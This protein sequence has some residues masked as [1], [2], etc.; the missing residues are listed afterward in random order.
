MIK[1]TISIVVSL[2]SFYISFAQNV[3]IGIPIPNEKLDV[4]GNVKATGMILTTGGAEYDFLMKNNV[5]G[6]VG[7]K[8]G[9][10]AQAIHYMIATNAFFPSESG[11]AN[12]TNTLTGEIK[13]FAGNILPSGWL[14]CEGQL[15]NI[16]SYVPLF[17]VI[18]FTY[19][20]D[21]Q[22]VFAL[23]DLRGATPVSSGTSTGGY[24]W[25]LGEKSN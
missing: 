12:Y 10:G 9:H 25:N 6:G 8:K 15:L 20:G 5:G 14:F 19:G 21:G 17:Q 7:F 16:T 4:D 11:S 24:T 18:G 22:S 1:Q 13:L 3:G 2:F 23:P